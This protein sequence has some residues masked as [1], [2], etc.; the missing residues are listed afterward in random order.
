CGNSLDGIFCQRCTCKYCGKGAHYGY[1]CPS[2]VSVISNLKPCHNQNVKEF[3]QTLPSFHPTCYSEDENS[4]AYDS[5]PKFVNDSSNVFNP[6]SQS[7]MYSYEFY[8]NDA[9]YGH[10]CHLK[11][12]LS[13]IQNRKIPL[14]YEDDDDEESAT[15][16][17]DII[18]YELPP[19]I[20]TTPV[21]STKETKDSLIMRDEHLDTITEKE[22]N[23]FIKS[24]VK[25][26][27]PNPNESEN[28]RECDVPGCD[29]FTTFFNLLFDVD[30][31]FSSSYD[32][33]FS[34]EDIPK[35]IYSN[36]LFDEEIISIKIDPHHFN[37]ESGL[38][39]SLLNQDSLIISSSKIDYLLDEYAGE[40]IFL[41]SIP[42][43]IDE[44]DCNP[45]EEIR[46][47]EKLF[48]P[49]MAEIDLFLTSDGSIPPGIDSDYS[50]SER[51]ILFLERLLHDDPSPLLDILD[52]SNVIRIFP[53]L[54]TYP[55]TSLI[56][57]SSGSKDTI[58]DPGI[59]NFHFFSLEQDV[60]HRIETFMKFNVYLNHLNKSLMEI[61]SSTCSPMDQ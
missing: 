58:F 32:K 50:D 44:A 6:P 53:P 23:E 56:L 3:P 10:D 37:V 55:V 28:E 29:D 4:F 35:E 42:P 8:G 21:L 57:F 26:L 12:Y 14:C 31:N 20:A 18:I 51:D 9:Q 41:K 22:S 38:I 24:S 39:E 52:F 36:P 5:T 48:D 16:M 7:P 15:P 54:F 33:S 17:R 30:D 59:S 11:F 13:I 61:L 34:D 49:F 27:V 47:I 43:G 1:N 19:C 2:K 25:N 40:L 60:S 46:L 45:E